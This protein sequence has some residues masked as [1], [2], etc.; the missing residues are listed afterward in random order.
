[1]AGDV[2]GAGAGVFNSGT[3]GTDRPPAT[4]TYDYEPA[5]PQIL[6][7][8]T[9][10]AAVC[11]RHGVPLPA[12]AAQF[13]LAHPAVATVCLGALS[14]AQVERNAA[15]FEAEIPSAVWAELKAEGLLRADAPTP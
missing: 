2:A 14:A 5:P 11:E 9:K 6:E 12:A 10:I 8:A 1:V 7:R 13:P 4:A 15:L 3:P